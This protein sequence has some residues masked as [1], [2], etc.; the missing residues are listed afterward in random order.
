MPDAQ[1]VRQGRKNLERFPR[2]ALL[3]FR[4]HRAQGSHVVQ[5]VRELDD[6]DPDVSGHGN[7]HL[8]Q[9]LGLLVLQVLP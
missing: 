3:L 6:D 4:L 9:V 7:Q 2:D 1:T 5:T 8:A